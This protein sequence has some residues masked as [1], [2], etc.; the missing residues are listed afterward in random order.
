MS[1]NKDNLNWFE[2]WFNS[3]YYHVLYQ[4]RDQTEAELF[5]SNLLNY[6][7]PNANQVLLDVACGQGRH[8]ITMHRFGFKVDAFDLSENSIVKA[9]KFE[10][11]QLRFFVNDIRIPLRDNQYDYVFNLFTSFGYF[12]DDDDNIKAIQAIAQSM[13]L[14]ATFVLDFMN[15]TKVL[16]ELIEEEIKVIDNISFKITKKV[17]DGFIVKTI[18]FNDKGKDFSFQER[19]KVIDEA[20]FIRYF[21]AANLKIETTFGNYNLNSFDQ[22]TSERLILVGKK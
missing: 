3:P 19:V 4:N 9:K 15:V 18:A 22:N 14:N 1:K 17:V 2:D 8:A 13:K 20:D 10:T 21:K 6:L 16:N 7:K 5:I 11:D 12:E